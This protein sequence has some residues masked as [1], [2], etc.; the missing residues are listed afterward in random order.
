MSECAWL[1]DMGYV[2]KT[3]KKT[4]VKLDYLSA[5]ALLSKLYGPTA[6]Y[7]FNSFD[8]AYGISDGLRGFYHAM[9][10]QGMVVC[11][12]PMSGNTAAGDH[13]QR[14]VDVDLACHA[15]W[16]ASLSDVERIV[17]T[18]GDQDMSP[19][20]KLCQDQLGV[21]VVLFTFRRDVSKALADLANEHLYFEDYRET[22]SKT[23]TKPPG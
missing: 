2:V 11:L 3:A 9:A 14:R 20:A 18:T 19:A 8:E 21:Q 17:L 10:Q 23:A 5:K 6:A 12:H 4:G 13:R 15:V 16:Q 1:V 22:L 7:L